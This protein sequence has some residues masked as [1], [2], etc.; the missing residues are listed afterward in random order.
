LAPT[1]SIEQMRARF[2][3]DLRALPVKA[4]RLAHPEHV[5]VHRSAALAALT[6]ETAEA[7]RRRVRSS[8]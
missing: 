4:A 2:E 8:D 3:T 5:V 7:A 6:A 1:P